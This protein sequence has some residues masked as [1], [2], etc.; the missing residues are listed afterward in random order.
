MS[1]ASNE[2]PSTGTETIT[3]D[4]STEDSSDERR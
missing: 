2:T 1:T 3:G 4:S